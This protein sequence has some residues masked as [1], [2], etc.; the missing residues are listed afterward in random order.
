MPDFKNET[1]AWQKAM[2]GIC[3]SEALRLL[4]GPLASGALCSLSN[5]L[6]LDAP[7]G[8]HHCLLVPVL[9]MPGRII[10]T[11]EQGHWLLGRMETLETHS[12]GSRGTQQFKHA[13]RECDV[14]S[15]LA[16]Y[17]VDGSNLV[18]RPDHE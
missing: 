7:I 17:P 16:P 11:P 9:L 2:A 14:S 3:E 12:D 8:M 1:Q 6:G 18:N 5:R 10:W 13:A 4:H 15:K